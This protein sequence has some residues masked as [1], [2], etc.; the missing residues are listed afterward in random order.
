MIIVRV[1]RPR[2]DQTRS[3]GPSVTTPDAAP[4]YVHNEGSLRLKFSGLNHTTFDLTVYAS[5]GELP[6]HHARLVSGCWPGFARRDS[7]P[8]GSSER[9]PSS[10][11]FLPSQA[12][13]AQ[14]H[15]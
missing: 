11:L 5:Q 15:P 10:R 2:Q 12:F 8:Q 7:Y 1:L 14:G 6:H 4:A 3:V 13:L 9:F